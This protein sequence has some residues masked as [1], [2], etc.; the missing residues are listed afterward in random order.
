MGYWDLNQP[1][2]NHMW[3]CGKMIWV[4]S[5]HCHT[6]II[7]YLSINKIQTLLAKED[8]QPR[9]KDQRC[10]DK[11]KLDVQ[12]EYETI[13]ND[14]ALSFDVCPLPSQ[15]IS[16]SLSAATEQSQF[17]TSNWEPRL[18]EGDPSKESVSSWSLG[19]TSSIYRPRCPRWTQKTIP[20][21]V[22]TKDTRLLLITARSWRRN[23]GSLT[24][25]LTRPSTMNN[26]MG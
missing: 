8:A 2:T 1:W 24:K 21:L 6:R 5:Y 4:L 26:K 14:P 11:A 13:P 17:L 25:L 15:S 16:L 20:K 3:D 12:V 9:K 19:P 22:R 23:D 7:K 18:S 10:W